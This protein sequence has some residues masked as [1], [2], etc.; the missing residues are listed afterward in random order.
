MELQIIH[1]IKNIDCFTP[2]HLALSVITFKKLKYVYKETF[3]G[4]VHLCIKYDNSKKKLL[5]VFIICGYELDV[6]YF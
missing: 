3:K 1:L 6:P 2:I 4:H 5:E